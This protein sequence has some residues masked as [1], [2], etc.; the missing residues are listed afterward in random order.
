MSKK[1]KILLHVAGCIIYLI[2]NLV[3]SIYEPDLTASMVFNVTFT[4]VR[5][6]QFYFCY[7]L[8][9]PFFLDWKNIPKTVFAIFLGLSI[10]IFLRYFIEQFTFSR[11]FGFQNYGK[12]FSSSFYLVSNIFYGFSGVFFTI[13]IYSTEKALNREKE[14]AILR[15]EATKA[16][17]AFLKS[18]INPHFLYN[19]LNYIYSLALPVSEQLASAIIRLSSL[20]RYTLQES[21]DGKV[22]LTKEI[23][24][25]ESYIELFKMRFAPNFYVDFKIYGTI[26]QQKIAVLLLIPFVENAFKHGVVNDQEKPVTIHLT[27]NGNKLTFELKNYINQQQKDQSSGIGLNNIKK[28]LD[29]IYPSQ[30]HLTIQNDEK[31][32]QCLLQITLD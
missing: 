30:Y 29:L 9:F 31:F 19:T 8:I 18:Q 7:L 32:Y 23:E 28:R 24:Y 12:H 4:L 11:L 1:K 26:D 14:N 3:P 5:I 22:L 25:I 15:Q 2:W 13:A 10:F 6:T 17:L 16:E 27:V 20:M 21:E